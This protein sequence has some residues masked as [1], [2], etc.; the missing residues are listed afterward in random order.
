MCILIQIVC[1]VGQFFIPQNVRPVVFGISIL[2]SLTATVFVFIL[3]VR[4]Y[5]TGLGVLY[6]ILA[7]VPCVG[8]IVLLVINGKA[9]STLRANGVK[10]GLLGAN[11]A[12]LPPAA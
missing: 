3:A 7:L 2:S 12:Q 9:T 1:A 4:V 11:L 6:G 10:V 8:L 5:G